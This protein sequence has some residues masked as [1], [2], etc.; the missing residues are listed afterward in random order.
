MGENQTRA[1]YRQVEFDETVRQALDT[2]F[3]TQAFMS[4][5]QFREAVA[6]VRNLA[7]AYEVESGKS[8]LEKW[9][10]ELEWPGYVDDEGTPHYHPTRQDVSKW[11]RLII[12]FLA[13]KGVLYR[14]VEYSP[15]TLQ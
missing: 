9:E 4:D 15:A 2:V 3:Q 13:R 5:D 6:G 11:L 14:R 12:R 7:A 8:L 10:D 1:D